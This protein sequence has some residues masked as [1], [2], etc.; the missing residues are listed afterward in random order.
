[1][2]STLKQVP[3]SSIR[4]NEVA[5]RAV[6]IKSE[7]YLNIEASMKETGQLLSILSREKTDPDTGEVY[8][9]LVDGLHR[10]T[11]AKMLGIP[12]MDLT[13]MDLDDQAMLEAQVIANIH[14]VD[15]KPAEYGRQLR[16][17]LQV[18]TMMTLSE[19]GQKLGVSTEWIKKRLA[20]NNI[21]N[22]RI[23]GLVD[24]GEIT[25]SNAF[26]L[27][28]LPTEAEMVNLIDSACLMGAAEFIPIVE[29][30]VKELRDASRKG[31][32]AAPKEF[33]PV[34]HCRKTAEILSIINSDDTDNIVYN[35][36]V[37][38]NL[39]AKQAGL[40][41]LKWVMHLDDESVAE[42]KAIWDDKK[43]KKEAA[44][45]KRASEA[46][47]KKAE[48]AEKAAAAAA[49]AEEAMAASN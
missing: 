6:S 44:A 3:L 38:T 46:A 35:I 2:S 48:K 4:E 5:L 16:R 21:E 30:R 27:S 20:M 7:K 45:A 12:T 37:A 8:Y 32:K 28:K 26:A 31:K 11:A 47:K 15:T 22:D 10:Y 19:L 33:A 25:L 43:A 42:Q 1:M 14:R 23:R 17:I 13:I 24:E 39:D 36:C 9:E 40:A 29:D 41:M 18:N 34:S 49:E